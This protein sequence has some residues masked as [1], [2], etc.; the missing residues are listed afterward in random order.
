[1]YL[2]VSSKKDIASQNIKQ[3]ILEMV[4]VVKDERKEQY[5][6]YFTDY[7]L[8]LV[9]IDDDLIYSDYLDQRLRKYIEFDEILFLS[10]HSSKDRRK[11]FS[12][13]CTGNLESAEYGGKPY[14]LAIPASFTMKNFLLALSKRINRKPEFQIMLEA[15]HHGPTEINVPMAFYE[16]GSTE[17][18]WKD[19]KAAEIVAESLLEAIQNKRKWKIAVGIGGT[20]YVPRQTEIMLETEFCFGHNFAKYTFDYLNTDILILAA[21]I[22]KAECFIIDEKSVNKAV[23]K[24]VEDAAKSLGIPVYKTKEIKKKYKLQEI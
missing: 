6:F 18:E 1:M 19:L 14:S 12:T 16:I 13:H 24:I 8:I 10:R 21:K 11:I 3:K 23:K 5:H 9:E 7:D 17:E 2:A 4:N 20:H 15:T 22:S